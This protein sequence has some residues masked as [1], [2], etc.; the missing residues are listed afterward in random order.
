MKYAAVSVSHPAAR[1][2]SISGKIVIRDSTL[3]TES[4]DVRVLAK[5]AISRRIS[6]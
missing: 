2:S 6:K 3:S 1:L 4:Y 5:L